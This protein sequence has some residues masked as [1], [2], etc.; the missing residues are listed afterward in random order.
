MQGWQKENCSVQPKELEAVNANTFIQRRNI[1]RFERDSVDGSK[2][3]EVGY[4]C[5]YRFISEGEYYTLLQQEENNVAVNDNLLVSMEAQAEIYEK[6][7]AQEENQMVIMQ[8]IA[9]LYETQ[10]G[11]V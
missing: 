6:M 11:G 2:E 8:A 3:K 10:N 9:D 4:S 7:L 5:E 1:T